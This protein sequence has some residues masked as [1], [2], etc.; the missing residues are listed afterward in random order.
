MN[1]RLL[2][3]ILSQS[4]IAL[5][6]EHVEA[7]SLR[8]QTPVPVPETTLVPVTLDSFPLGAADHLNV[9]EDLNKVGYVEESTLSVVQPTSMTG[10]LPEL[11]RLAWPMRLTPHECW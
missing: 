5:V 8:A 11:P 9:P 2:S 4:L 7:E 10:R 6:A 3:I 1:K